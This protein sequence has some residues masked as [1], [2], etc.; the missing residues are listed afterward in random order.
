MP[1]LALRDLGGAVVWTNDDLFAE[2]QN[3]IKTAPAQYQPATFGHKG[4]VYDGWETRRRRVGGVDQAIVR[5]GAP[6]VIY[7]VVVDT[8]W[9]K[10]NYPPFISVEA[11]AVEGVVSVDQLLDDVEWVTIVEKTAAEGDTRNPF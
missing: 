9:F 5:L 1:D 11:A 3:L 6:G 8:S 7:G 4:Q 2:A 10:G